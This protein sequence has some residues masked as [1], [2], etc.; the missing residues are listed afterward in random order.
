VWTG[1]INSN[2]NIM[3]LKHGVAIIISVTSSLQSQIKEED[4][5]EHTTDD[6]SGSK[7]VSCLLYSYM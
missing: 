6:I 4:K 3:M 1:C 5:R 2:M 7:P